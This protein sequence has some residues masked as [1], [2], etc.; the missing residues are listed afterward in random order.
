M[1]ISIWVN[2]IFKLVKNKDELSINSADLQKDRNRRKADIAK[3]Q[4]ILEKYLTQKYK[5][6]KYEIVLAN[7]HLGL[8]PKKLTVTDLQTKLFEQS[9]VL[10]GN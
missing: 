2:N 9:T 8:K 1:I 4:W 7:L 6:Q 10:F 3:N 5:I